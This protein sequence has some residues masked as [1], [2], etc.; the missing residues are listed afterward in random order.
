MGLGL[1]LEKLT[2]RHPENQ[3]QTSG[4]LLLCIL[5]QT[6]SLEIDKALRVFVVH[7]PHDTPFCVIPLWVEW[8]PPF[9]Q[10]HVL[11]YQSPI[12]KNATLFGKMVVVDIVSKAEVLLK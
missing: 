12:P 2:S 7:L 10:I 4:K 11:K 5:V 8:C 6:S 9:P 1:L 3:V